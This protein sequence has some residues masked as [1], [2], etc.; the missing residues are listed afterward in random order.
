MSNL[1][2]DVFGEY[3][4]EPKYREMLKDTTFSD[5]YIHKEDLKLTANLHF[6]E[7]KNIMCLKATA[8][9]IKIALRF[10]TV[11][12]NFFLPPEALDYSCFP[13]LLKVL[14]VNVPQTNGF[15]DNSEYTYE[16]DT[17]TI[18]FLSGGCDICKNAAAD[19]FLE[20]YIFEHFGKK[21][22]VNLEGENSNLE[23]FLKVQEEIAAE[24]GN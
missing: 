13:M 24:N 15:L 2:L 12:F 17:L 22:T 3:I 5:L 16:D 20:N 18:K 23:D 7:F 21:I 10:K 6:K 14:K 19:T 9:E 1:F 8:N 4:S 11:E